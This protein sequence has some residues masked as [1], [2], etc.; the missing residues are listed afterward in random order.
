MSRRF[1][2]PWRDVQRIARPLAGKAL[3]LGPV[4]AEESPL[5]LFSRGRCCIFRTAS[6]PGT[7]SHLLFVPGVLGLSDLKPVRVC[8]P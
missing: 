1:P 6:K 7:D 8:E 2:A 4:H 5:S 3:A